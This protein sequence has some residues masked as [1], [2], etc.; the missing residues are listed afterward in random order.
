MNKSKRVIPR[1]RDE[2]MRFKYL[3]FIL[4]TSRNGLHKGTPF[5]PSKMNNFFTFFHHCTLSIH[6]L[7]KHSILCIIKCFLTSIDDYTCQFNTSRLFT[8]QIECIH[9]L[10]IHQWFS[11]IYEQKHTLLFHGYLPI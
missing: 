7:V 3:L 2:T 10:S 9:S 4:N 8:M 1:N 6:K 11:G 5:F